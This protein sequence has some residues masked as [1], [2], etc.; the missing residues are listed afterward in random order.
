MNSRSLSPL[1]KTVNLMQDW[2][3]GGE[4]VPEGPTSSK[5]LGAEGNMGYSRNGKGARE[6]RER[7]SDSR[8]DLTAKKAGNTL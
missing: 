6:Q 2:S 3:R 8:K 7:E 5:A 1:S 4:F